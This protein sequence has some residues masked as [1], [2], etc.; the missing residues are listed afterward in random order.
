MHYNPQCHPSFLFW[1]FYRSNTTTFQIT[2]N[3][4]SD[5][6]ARKRLADLKYLVNAVMGQNSLNTPTLDEIH[7]K[8]NYRQ[9]KVR[10]PPKIYSEIQE[11]L[12]LEWKPPSND[13]KYTS[14]FFKMEQRNR[15]SI[16]KF[17][18]AL[19]ESHKKCNFDKDYKP[20][21]TF[22][23]KILLFFER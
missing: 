22:F 2:P 10:L 4:F 14:S 16:Q 21:K 1:Q 18:H 3:D 11:A 19:V 5:S 6:N 20:C 23:P 7:L 9:T 13:I 17:Y 12:L 15:Q 8:W